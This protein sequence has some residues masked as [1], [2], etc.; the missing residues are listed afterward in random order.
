MITEASLSSNSGQ[1][2]SNENSAWMARNQE[3]LD[4]K[5]MKEISAR[6]MPEKKE[7]H[8]SSRGHAQGI[9]TDLRQTQYY[10]VPNYLVTEEANNCLFKHINHLAPGNFP[11]YLLTYRRRSFPSSPP[12]AASPNQGCAAALRVAA[13]GNGCCCRS[14]DPE[15]TFQHWPRRFTGSDV[16]FPEALPLTD[17]SAWQTSGSEGKSRLPNGWK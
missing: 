16:S 8:P 7:H 17:I 9:C 3:T 13:L 11:V 14:R 2:G 4:W 12:S 10:S 15:M 1:S 5:H 6:E